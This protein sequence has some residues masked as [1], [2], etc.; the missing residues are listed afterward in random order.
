MSHKLTFTAALIALGIVSSVSAVTTNEVHVTGSTAFRGNFFTAATAAAGGIFDAPGGTALNGATSGSGLVTFVGNIGTVPYAL[1]CS[2]TGSEAGIANVDGVGTLANPGLPNG[3][4]GAANLPGATTTF[5]KIDGTSGGFTGTGDLTLADTSQAVSLTKPPAHPA[6]HDYGVIGVVT[7]VWEK[8]VNSTGTLASTNA[9]DVA[10][11]RL[12]NVT[13]PEMLFCLAGTLNANFLTGNTNDNTTPVVVVG[14]NAGSGTRVNTLLDTAYGVGNS[15]SQ[16]ALNSTYSGSGVLTYKVFANDAAS[17]WPAVK[18]SLGNQSDYTTTPNLVAV[19]DDGYESG[20]GVSDCLSCDSS[21]S[22]LITLGYVGLGDAKH[23]RDG[24]AASGTTPA[25]P[26]GAVFLTLDGNAYNDAV[27]INGTYSFW[28][29][30]HLYGNSGHT[31]II[32]N[33]AGAIKTGIASAGALGTGSASAQSSGI[34][35]GDMLA[36]KSGDTGYPSPL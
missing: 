20:G 21:G 24:Q 27:V 30:E 4:F 26:G 5:P 6:L 32:D 34:V 36:D 25:Q 7:F 8:G 29:H 13:Q 31:T 12:S 18:T 33:A 35:Y 3:G 15:V 22:S 23:A 28:G 9:G 2:W 17:T 11:A 10:W 16:F 19:G 1:E 14:R